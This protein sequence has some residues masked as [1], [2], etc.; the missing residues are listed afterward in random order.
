[1][2]GRGAKFMLLAAALLRSAYVQAARSS[3]QETLLNETA[4][5][6]FSNSQQLIASKLHK[7][8]ADVTDASTKAAEMTEQVSNKLTYYHNDIKD[9]AKVMHT[10]TA[11]AHL[12]RTH[13]LNELTENEK[14]R[15]RPLGIQPNVGGFVPDQNF[16]PDTH[17]G[18]PQVT[19]TEPLA[20]AQD[21]NKDGLYDGEHDVDDDQ[22][23]LQA[24]ATEPLA[25]ST[26]ME[27]LAI[28]QDENKPRPLV[29]GG[30][31]GTSKNDLYDGR[32]DLYDDQS[33]MEEE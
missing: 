19:A 9:M 17:Q 6:Y 22:G 21:E 27:P 7:A 28:A 3:E 16:I 30:A 2:I 4:Q 26:R 8:A 14:D 25:E 13:Y 5:P 29:K 15:L 33:E 18:S 11:T 20:I 32:H 1:M 12:L 23:S 10:V 24:T 31:W